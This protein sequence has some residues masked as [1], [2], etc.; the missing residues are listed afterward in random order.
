MCIHCCARRDAHLQLCVRQEQPCSQYQM[1]CT[2]CPA[3]PFAAG[4]SIRADLRLSS[5][6][7]PSN[8]MC[9]ND[10]GRRGLGIGRKRGAMRCGVRL[11]RRGSA[12]RGCVGSCMQRLT[13]RPGTE[14]THQ[15]LRDSASGS[16]VQRCG[17]FV[18]AF[19]CFSA[20]FVQLSCEGRIR[21]AAVRC[22][23]R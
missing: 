5:V 12:A 7:H 16:S 1:H 8:P 2:R 22:S 18:A 9:G 20:I 11:L 21:S 14:Q 10:A 19:A 3:P 23:M 13:H 6:P 4:P 17:M 15:C